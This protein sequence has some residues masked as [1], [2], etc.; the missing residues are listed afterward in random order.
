MNSKLID[1]QAAH[2]QTQSDIYSK[3]IYIYIYIFT[4]KKKYTFYSAFN[5]CNKIKSPALLSRGLIWEHEACR[6]WQTSDDG[7]HDGGCSSLACGGV[8]PGSCSPDLYDSITWTTENSIEKT[9][10]FRQNALDSSERNVCVFYDQ[11]WKRHEDGWTVTCTDGCLGMAYY[12][13]SIPQCN[14]LN[15]IFHI[16]VDK[17]SCIF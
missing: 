2:A 14:E 1:W 9:C 16:F 8:R 7:H 4:I 11:T 3:D 17:N 12:F 10:A 15:L 5:F 13:C 6:L